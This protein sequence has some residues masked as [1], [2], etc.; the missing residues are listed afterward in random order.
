MVAGLAEKNGKLL[1]KKETL[2]RGTLIILKTPQ[3]VE[4]NARV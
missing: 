4:N 1:L 2:T 3:L